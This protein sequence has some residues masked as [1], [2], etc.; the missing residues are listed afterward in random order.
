MSESLIRWK[1]SDY[2]T[3]G[4]AVSDFNKKINKIKNEENKLYL[5]ELKNYES[6][7]DNIKTRKELERVINSLKKFKKEGAEKLVEFVSGETMT[8]WEKENLIQQQRIA[9]RSLKKTVKELETPST[10][11]GYS[12]AQMG[13]IEYQEALANLRSI[14]KLDKKLGREFKTIKS[15]IEKFRNIRLR[16]DKSNC[17]S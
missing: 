8:E 15:R 16:N 17:F 9:E 6:L 1:K 4:R 11:S 12:K 13:S 14:Q 2:L 5:P 3:L 10:A 7:R